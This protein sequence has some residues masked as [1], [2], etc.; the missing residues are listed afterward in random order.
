MAASKRSLSS[1]I[2]PFSSNLLLICSLAPTNVTPYTEVITVCFTSLRSTW[3]TKTFA[4]KAVGSVSGSFLLSFSMI[5]RTLA[6]ISEYTSAGLSPA[7][8][9]TAAASLLS[10]PKAA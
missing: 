3:S 2:T 10:L 1:V 7:T 6:A 9:F 8:K 5:S 4:N